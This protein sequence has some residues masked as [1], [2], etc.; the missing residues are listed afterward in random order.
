MLKR[1]VTAD[2]LAGKRKREK[3][4]PTKS[5]AIS[6]ERSLRKIA[7]RIG[8]LSELLDPDATQSPQPLIDALER[9][10]R[11]L[12][13]W[14]ESVAQRML[15][16][17]DRANKRDWRSHAA[18]MGR[19]LREEIE[20][21]PTGETL[22]LLQMEQV[23]LITSI[24]RE[25]ALRVQK[26]A[27]ESLITGSRSTSIRDEIMRSGEVTAS[28]ATLIARTET[29]K[30]STLLTQARAQAVGS[31]GYIWRSHRDARTRKSHRGMNG[32]FVAWDDPPELDGLQGH[33]GCIPNCRCFAMPVFPS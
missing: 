21:A 24:P 29:S 22:Q 14:A 11:T 7:K 33:A 32:Q 16:D 28:R 19:L 26:L 31:T 4:E 20:Q 30:A 3:F 23:A 9:Y 2:A 10:S 6:Y 1:V 15:E 27:R 5:L 12:E 18:Q 13:P 25:A 17:A 8:T